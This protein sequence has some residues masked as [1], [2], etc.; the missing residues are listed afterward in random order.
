MLL[1]NG[2]DR[3]HIA[4]Q[5]AVVHGH[6]GFGAGRDG[7]A[8]LFRV[9]V[10]RDRVHIHQHRIGPQIAHHLHRGGEGERRRNHLIARTYAQRLQRQMQTGGGGVDGNALHAVTAQV[11]GKS[12][13]KG[14]GFGASGDPTRAQGFGDGGNLGIGD[15]GAGEW[16][17]GCTHGFSI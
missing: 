3:V 8:D 7:G 13:L 17:E 16:E 1:G 11:V 12:L 5:A 15:V 10:Q 4:R 14:E 2:Q 6:D 9:N